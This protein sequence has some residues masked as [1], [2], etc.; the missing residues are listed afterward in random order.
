MVSAARR[1]R[2]NRRRARTR[3]FQRRRKRAQKRALKSAIAASDM[4]PVPS[5]YPDPDQSDASVSIVSDSSSGG[6]R[7]STQQ[8]GS[9]LSSTETDISQCPWCL[10]PFDSSG[11][12]PCN[13][14]GE[15]LCPTCW[16]VAKQCKLCQFMADS[17]SPSTSD[18]GQHMVER[19]AFSSI[20]GST[21]V[22]VTGL[23]SCRMQDPVNRERKRLKH[24][25]ALRMQQLAVQ[26]YKHKS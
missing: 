17:P 2:R 26:L 24:E 21:D 1:A 15:V 20:A 14:C 7:L 5:V 12:T 3:K 8:F 18:G 4:H 19:A 6:L 22:R 10:G 16:S 9:N 11:S 25:R 13:L 23:C